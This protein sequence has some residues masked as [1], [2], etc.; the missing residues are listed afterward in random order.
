MF[1]C[2]YFEWTLWY[3]IENNFIENNCFRMS[4]FLGGSTIVMLR[5]GPHLNIMTVFPGY[6]NSHIK[7]E[8][9]FIMG[10]PIYW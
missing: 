3:F 5:P 9:V 7:D 1:V 6:R 10:I 4:A 2:S 8:M